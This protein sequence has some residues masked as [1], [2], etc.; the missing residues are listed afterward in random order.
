MN[1]LPRRDAA[2]ADRLTA[3]RRRPRFGSAVRLRTMAL[4]ACLGLAPSFGSAQS[5][6]S[7]FGDGLM[8]PGPSN[9]YVGLSLGKSKFDPDCVP[10][11]SCDSGKAGFK[12]FAGA[13]STDVLGAEIAYLDMGRIDYAGGSQRA[14][15]LNLSLVGTLPVAPGFSAF[16]KVGATYG[17]TETRSRAA[18]VRTGDEKGFGISYGLGLGYRLSTQLEVI[19][20]YERH[21]FDFAPGS[22]TLGFTSVGLRYQY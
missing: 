16:G 4:V 15:G 3:V 12:V 11:L 20:E 22:Q 1:A 9:G 5:T 17:W 13:I 2:C 6:R 21:R 18:G 7:G 10:G 8:L 14:S 19:A